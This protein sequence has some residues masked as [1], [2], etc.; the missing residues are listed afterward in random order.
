MTLS[1][2]G[3]IREE[4]EEAFEKAFEGYYGVEPDTYW[5][6]KPIY[7]EQKLAFLRGARWMASKLCDYND[8]G[9]CEMEFPQACRSC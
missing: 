5:P 6:G 3:G 1:K 7:P 4:F 8:P 2:N 9:R